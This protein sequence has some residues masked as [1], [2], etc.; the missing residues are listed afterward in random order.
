MEKTRMLSNCIEDGYDAVVEYPLGPTGE[1]HNG[2][3]I[4][5]SRIK[6]ELI[7]KIGVYILVLCILLI[8]CTTR[9]AKR[10]KLLAEIATEKG[11]EKTIKKIRKSPD[12]YGKLNQFLFWYDLGVLY[13]Y[14]E[15]Y[16]S[17][18]A[19]L[20]RAEKELDDLYARS[21][22]NEI[23]SILTNDNLRPYRAKRYEQVMLHQL[24]SFNYLS[25][26]A[27]DEALVEMRKVQMVFDRFKSKDKGKDK[28]SDDGMTRFFSS[29]LYETQG[30][31]DDAVIALYKSVSA[32]QN[33]PISLPPDVKDLAYYNFLQ[34]E[35]EDDIAEL[36]LKPG[37]DREAVPGLYDNPQSEVVLIGYSGKGAVMG[38]TVFWGTYVV[39]GLLI[40]HYRNPYGDTV[41]LPLPAP[42]IPESERKKDKEG[43]TKSGTTFHI[44]FALPSMVT[45]KSLSDHF[46]VSLIDSAGKGIKSSPLTNTEL[47]LKKDMED[48]HARTVARTALRVVL[49]T[50]ASQKTK[51]G[52]T[53]GSPLANLFIN[54]GTDLLTDQ[55]EKADTRL[56]FFLPRTVH[57]ARIPVNPGIHTIKV[58]ARDSGGREIDQKVWSG[59]EVREGKKK[60][61]F[62]PV[63]K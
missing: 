37:R 34:E 49:R 56:C 4:V 14:N 54:F 58:S 33:G 48:N 47:L 61:I 35:R 8:S 19:C 20:E 17:S 3:G 59:V 24:L 15:Q 7:K 36:N 52:L 10:V 21:I 22:T 62:Y 1:L 50:I 12:L 11:Y 44:K 39:D 27:F 26:D 2:C 25:K 6:P 45:R 29:I 43:K 38:E 46:M 31:Q 23:A 57:I 18:I 42:P 16:D 5:S 63:L 40:V 55:L 9:S 13:H 28:Y 41:T 53:T 32:Y 60:F 51:K 30:D